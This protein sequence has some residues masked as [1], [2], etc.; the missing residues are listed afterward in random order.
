MDLG[1]PLEA[2]IGELRPLGVGRLGEGGGVAHEPVQAHGEEGVAGVAE[3]GIAVGEAAGIGQDP[4]GQFIPGLRD[5]ADFGGVIGEDHAVA[6]VGHQPVGIHGGL[7]LRISKI[8]EHGSIDGQQSLFVSAAGS[9]S[10]LE[11]GGRAHD[12][13]E[14]PVFSGGIGFA[15]TCGDAGIEDAGADE[16]E[17]HRRL[18]VRAGIVEGDQLVERGFFL[19]RAFDPQMDHRPSLSVEA[20]LDDGGRRLALAGAEGQGHEDRQYQC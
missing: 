1:Q 20:G 4:V 19:L 13:I 14:A 7:H 3:I 11:A 5:L 2:G 16:L 8:R 6:S 12:D 9:H 10:L 17:L 18:P 15:V